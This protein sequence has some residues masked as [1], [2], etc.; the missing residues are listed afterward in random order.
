[1]PLP[2]PFLDTGIVQT[3]QYDFNIQFR[4]QFPSGSLTFPAGFN[5][6]VET[7]DRSMGA[8]AFGRTDLITVG[9]VP[10]A[11]ID[12]SNDV[13]VRLAYYPGGVYTEVDLVSGAGTGSGDPGLL[14]VIACRRVDGPYRLGVAMQ[15]NI[16]TY[17][18]FSDGATTVTDT[19]GGI[20]TYT[21]PSFGQ[22]AVLYCVAGI[23][24]NGG[25]GGGIG[26]PGG[27]SVYSLMQASGFSVDGTG[28]S[29]GPYDYF[30][31]GGVAIPPHYFAPPWRWSVDTAA[32]DSAGLAVNADVSYNAVASTTPHVFSVTEEIQGTT[33]STVARQVGIA[34]L[35]DPWYN[36]Q[37]IRPYG[38]AFTLEGNRPKDPA[39]GA[40]TTWDVGTLTIASPLTVLLGTNAWA[41]DSGTV[42]IGGTSTVPTFNVTTAPAVVHR[43]LKSH[44]RNWNTVADPLYQGLDQYTATKHNA[45][46]TGATTPDVWGWGL[47]RYLDVDLTVPADCDLAL[48]VTWAV[49]L[50]PV[51]SPTALG[52]P[53]PTIVTDTRTY[54][55]VHFTAGRSTQRLDLMFPVEVGRPWYGERVDRVQLVGLQLGNHTLHSLKLTT[56]ENA[57]LTIVDQQTTDDLQVVFGGV[58]I[59]QDGQ[60]AH[61]HWGRDRALPAVG[62]ETDTDGDGYG[63]YAKDHQNGLM[64]YAATSSGIAAEKHTGGAFG[65]SLS[66]SSHTMQNVFTELNLLEGLTATYNDANIA[67]AFTDGTNSITLRFAGY[68]QPNHPYARVAAGAAYTVLARLVVTDVALASG[69]TTTASMRFFQRV[70]LG[71]LVEALAVD[72]S[73]NAVGAG[74]TLTAK[75]YV[76][77]APTGSDPTWATGTTDVSGFAVLTGGAGQVLES[78]SRTEFSLVLEGS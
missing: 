30:Y 54:S 52:N 21:G 16:L 74:S 46:P 2:A 69:R 7:Y 19:I 70:R 37:T 35:A 76:G 53:A 17:E 12:S 61:C 36:A 62:G 4:A 23:D 28:L 78:G 71:A 22:G 41:T 3:F 15:G 45:Y 60:M 58:T 57:Y 73:E 40:V 67:A 1:M 18:W 65:M 43:D 56:A 34:T 39:Q 51:Q 9:G 50:D 55:P 31:N 24:G 29:G 75:Q 44:W 77:A 27:V 14:P 33:T 25:T 63:D 8:G 11:G 72:A 66:S 26:L 13:A 20:T 5:V 32:L 49:L 64:G 6:I 59:A 68:L 42:I 10:N 38:T 47:Y 48:T